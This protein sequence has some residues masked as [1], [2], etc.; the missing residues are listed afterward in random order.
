MDALVTGA[1]GFIGS[2]LVPRLLERGY[3]VRC[4]VRQAS[5]L[6]KLEGLDVEFFPGNLGDP[7]SLGRAVRGVDYVFHLAGLTKTGKSREFYDI[8]ACGTENL[9]EAAVAENPGLR[10]FVYLSSHAAAGPSLNGGLLTEEKEPQPV[11]HYGRSKLM[12]EKAVLGRSSR[13]PVVVLRPTS[14]YGPGDRDVYLLFKAIKKG[15]FPYWGA[16]RYSLLYVEDL[17]EGIIAAAEAGA[18]K[19]DGKVFFL[20]DGNV[21]TNS[22]IAETIA[23]ALSAHPLKLPLP[24]FLL[25]A[26]AL[27]SALAGKDSGIINLDKLREMGFPNWCC[28]P[29]RAIREIGFLP[30]ITLKE[31]AKWT[32]NWYRIRQWL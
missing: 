22:E 30:K 3:K 18:D 1:T 17:A 9:V 25:Y 15:I 28:D 31:G 10:K 14:V 6:E 4:L 23:D 26:A 8:N 29:G 20:S 13:I 7:A 11:S 21:Y 24:R 12:G 2:H 32:V 16:G 19:S 5:S 27:F